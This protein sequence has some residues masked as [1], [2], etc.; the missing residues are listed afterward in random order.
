MTPPVPVSPSAPLPGRAVQISATKD[1]VKFST[2]G[3]VGTANITVR[4]NNTADKV[5][6]LRG[7]GWLLLLWFRQHGQSQHWGV[8]SD[9]RGS[10]RPTWNLP[11]LADCCLTGSRLSCCCVV[12]AC[13]C[14]SLQKEDQVS[15]DLTEPVSLTF[16]LRYLNSFAKA[17]P[18]SGA[19]P[20]AARGLA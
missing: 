5:G 7:G 3:D 9:M 2:S 17:T 13:A 14:C 11:W 20:E 10:L 19:L 15:I 1:G 4:Q 8:N 6:R 16:A 12:A 18:L